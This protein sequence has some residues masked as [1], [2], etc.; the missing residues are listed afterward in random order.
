MKIRPVLILLLAVLI[1]VAVLLFVA[2]IAQP[3]DYY[4]FADGRRLLGIS[5][6]SNVASNLPF[7]LV[8]AS[9]LYL[10]RQHKLVHDNA[11]GFPV[12]TWFFA[13]VLLTAFG[14]AWF[15]LAPGTA[16]LVWDRL[17]IT[18]AFMALT[19][20]LLSEHPALA[21]KKTLD[22][23][24]ALAPKK[25][26]AL[27]KWLLYPLLLIGLATVIYWYATEQAGAGDLRPYLLVQFMPM[28][29]L[30]VVVAGCRSRFS[31]RVD[32]AW[33]LGCY[34]LAKVAEFYDRDLYDFL[35]GLSGH[36]IKHLLA[37][38]ACLL[39]LRMLRLRKPVLT[40]GC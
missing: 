30:P 1:P 31:R 11:P 19:T 21:Q 16:S 33:V 26:L 6:F 12:Y 13:G 38:T 36:S 15:H 27:E 25:T 40:A 32:L 4:R 34:G 3:L 17:P 23:K 5:N 24:K 29:L 8:G 10:D 35:G 20:G 37:A 39:V 2:P 7:L 22:P 14:S 28:I 9:G 18:M